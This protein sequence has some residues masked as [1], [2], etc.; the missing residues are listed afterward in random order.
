M[1]YVSD[2][3]AGIHEHLRLLLRG[4]GHTDL[5]SW[6]DDNEEDAKFARVMFFLVSTSLRRRHNQDSNPVAQTCTIADERR[7]FDERLGIAER[8]RTLACNGSCCVG[9]TVATM[10]AKTQIPH[11]CFESDFQSVSKA[12]A[13]A[14]AYLLTVADVERRHNRAKAGLT[15]KGL[16]QF[17]NFCVR[18]LAEEIRAVSSR[19]A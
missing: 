14:L 2:L 9:L 6:A 1:L 4:T 12:L 13:Y 8:V 3:C 16:N 7:P 18:Q 17:K 10:F 15:R 11:D 5:L 19:S